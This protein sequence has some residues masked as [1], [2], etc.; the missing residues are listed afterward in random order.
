MDRYTFNFTSFE[1]LYSWG[2]VRLSPLVLR[3]MGL[4]M[5]L[6]IG[7][8]K[9]NVCLTK[10]LEVEKRF[11]CAYVIL[12]TLECFLPRTHHLDDSKTPFLFVPGTATK[13]LTASRWPWNESCACAME[14]Y[15]IKLPGVTL[16]PELSVYTRTTPPGILLWPACGLLLTFLPP[17][18]M[19][20]RNAHKY[21]V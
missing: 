11:T 14:Q 6:D 16:V 2:G 8:K 20:V 19:K 10:I 15:G 12:P 18:P 7:G 5:A 21:M 9:C 3:L 13:N 1:F 17:A 4:P